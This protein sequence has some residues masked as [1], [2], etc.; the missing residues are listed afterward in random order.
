MRGGRTPPTAA[1]THGERFLYETILSDANQADV[2]AKFGAAFWTALVA[3]PPGQWQGPLRSAHGWHLVY[4]SAYT[5]ERLP[6][7]QELGARLRE[8]AL[9]ARQEQVANAAL[10]RVLEDYRVETADLPE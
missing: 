2:T 1:A 5:P 9:A 3:L 6:T 7:A 8:D 10:E 4:V